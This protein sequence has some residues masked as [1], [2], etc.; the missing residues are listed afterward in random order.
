MSTLRADDAV[1]GATDDSVYAEAEL[2]G[3]LLLTNAAYQV[4]LKSCFD[5]ADDSGQDKCGSVCLTRSQFAVEQT[6]D[7][8][9][10]EV[11]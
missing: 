4:R 11:P 5:A 7:V 1:F 6:A 8:Y 3:R 10:T 2:N 9:E